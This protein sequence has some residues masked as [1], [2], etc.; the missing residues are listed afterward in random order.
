MRAFKYKGKKFS[1]STEGGAIWSLSAD[2]EIRLLTVNII[3]T[4]ADRLK[5]PKAACT[6]N[7]KSS[8]VKVSSQTNPKLFHAGGLKLRA[9][10]KK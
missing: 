8:R 9:I 10:L 3:K 6:E 5:S 7:S 2:S 4:I 1:K